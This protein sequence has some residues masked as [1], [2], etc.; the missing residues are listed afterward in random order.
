MAFRRNAW[1][2]DMLSSAV[3]SAPGGESRLSTDPEF[4]AAV[5]RLREFL[6]FAVSTY[7]AHLPPVVIAGRDARAWMDAMVAELLEDAARS[8]RL[9]MFIANG[10]VR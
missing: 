5:A 4:A 6:N 3:R 10:E 8:E 9:R 1:L 7:P 2:E